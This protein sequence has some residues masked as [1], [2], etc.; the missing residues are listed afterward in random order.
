ML[1]KKIHT[2]AETFIVKIPISRYL[3]GCLRSPTF[4][5]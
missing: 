1:K 2:A 5:E 4:L 3:A